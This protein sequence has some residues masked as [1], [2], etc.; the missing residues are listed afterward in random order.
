MAVC[1]SVFLTALANECYENTD[2]AVHGLSMDR[3]GL[4]YGLVHGLLLQIPSM[5]HPKN[6]M[7][8]DQVHRGSAD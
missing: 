4:P 5:D 6:S 7:P 8:I 3:H 2:P 1:I